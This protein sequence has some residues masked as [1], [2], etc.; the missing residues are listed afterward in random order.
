MDPCNEDHEDGA[1]EWHTDGRLCEEWLQNLERGK[2][3]HGLCRI[4][5]RLI[6]SDGIMHFNHVDRGQLVRLEV[7]LSQTLP[8]RTWF[9]SIEAVLV[10][11]VV[12]SRYCFGALH[13]VLDW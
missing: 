4:I 12:S 11:G 3:D 6:I 7:S 1:S 5:S 9:R 10:P 2:F 13:A 8:Q